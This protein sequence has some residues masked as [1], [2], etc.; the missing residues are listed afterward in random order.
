MQTA[1]V[2]GVF[3]DLQALSAQT[4]DIGVR[5]VRCRVAKFSLQTTK[6]EGPDGDQII[7]FVHNKLC[8]AR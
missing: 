6:I 1:L 2:C 4:V 5:A 3:N 7:R 8:N